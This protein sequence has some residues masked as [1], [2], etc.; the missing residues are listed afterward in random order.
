[1][2]ASPTPSAPPLRLH[3][4][5]HF[6]GAGNLGDDLMLAGLLAAAAE[7][8]GLSSAPQFTCCI[9]FDPAPQRLRS[10]SSLQRVQP[11]SG[12]TPLRKTGA[13]AERTTVLLRVSCRYTALR[14]RNRAPP[15][16]AQEGGAG[17]SRRR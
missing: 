17:C 6:Y 14:S 1:M 4:G 12:T 13:I 11:C 10:S 15:A 16:S 3:V 7:R 9:P 5:H 8:F 2:S